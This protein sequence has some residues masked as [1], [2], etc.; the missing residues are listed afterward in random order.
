MSNRLLYSILAIVLMVSIAGPIVS[1]GTAS[2]HANGGPQPLDPTSITKYVDPLV[3]P[4]A[5]PTSKL[6]GPGGKNIDYYEIAVRQFEQ[7]V[8]PTGM[9]MT[10]VW[11]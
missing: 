2:V 8:L 3:I 1:D 5:M 7:Q 9:P 11:S 4:P 10:T 6:M